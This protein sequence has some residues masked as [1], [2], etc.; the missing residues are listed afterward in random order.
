MLRQR[1]TVMRRT[2]AQV[3]SIESVNESHSQKERRALI[4]S[5]GDGLFLILVGV[6]ASLMMYLVHSLM[7]HLVYRRVWHLVLSLVVGMSLAMIIQTL[8]AFG[9][10]PILGSIESIV[11]S[12]VVA[13]IIPMLVCLLAL[14]GINVSRSGAL[15]LGAA[16]GISSFLLL[17][18]Y[19]CKCR[20]S[21]C[22]AFPQKG[23]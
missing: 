16:G 15:A 17:K 12:M 5:C 11:P 7:M 21:L 23:G 14:V 20:K 10:A 8:L 22:C 19:E 18:A 3:R 2:M 4:F 9:V 1:K 13:M 6:A